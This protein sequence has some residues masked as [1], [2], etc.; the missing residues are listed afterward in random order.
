[1]SQAERTPQLAEAFAPVSLGPGFFH[2][3][4]PLEQLQPSPLNPRKRFGGIEELAQ[5]IREIGV[6][7]PLVARPV[8]DHYELVAGERRYRAAMLAGLGAVPCTVR[9]LSDAQALEIMVIENNQRED[10]N[11]LEEADGFSR[12][13]KSGYELERLT[14]RL[15]R[16]K[17]Y[18]YDRVKLL[19]LAAPAKELLYNGVLTAGHGILLARL[20][21]AD[22][23][24][25]L[26]V[27]DGGVFQSEGGLTEEEEVAQ[28]EA[29]HKRED[30]NYEAGRLRKSE[31]GFSPRDVVG[32]KPKSVRETARWISQHVRF[33]AHEMAVAAPLEFGEVAERVDLAL[34]KPGRGKKV[35]AITFD[36]YVQPEARDESDRTFGPRSFKFADGKS[37]CDYGDYG[38]KPK[39]TKT[40]EHSVLGVVAVG[41]KYGQAFDVCISRDKC[42][43][44]WKSEMAERAKNQKSGKTAKV[45]REDADSAHES[46]MAKMRR[47]REESERQEAAW[48]AI[49]ER[50]LE[51][52][53]AALK[54]GGPSASVIDALMSKTSHLDPA[55]K[56]LFARLM[57][58]VTAANIAIA[59][60]FADIVDDVARDHNEFVKVAKVYGVDL[61]D[62]TTEYKQ[63]LAP[64]AAAKPVQ[65]SAPKKKSAKKKR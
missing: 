20:K 63:L 28:E 26:D 54:K 62:L 39:P 60:L 5:N 31:P 40:C 21:P 32:M 45:S 9:H 48:D 13:L 46:W 10:V 24:R 3:A 55:D 57:G 7:Q 15:G 4:M 49:R 8:G 59:L 43:V 11:A 41:E 1:M 16:S 33:K 38:T 27:D 17:K 50:A 18:V 34:L 42:Q 29:L 30:R 14:E 65:T 12:L 47:E 53:A 23:L 2:E 44:H 25:A 64:K 52:L 58:K 56:K 61:A 19:D 22:Q 36:H 35:I 6:L 51:R 37:H